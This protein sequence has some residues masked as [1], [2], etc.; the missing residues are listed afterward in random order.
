MEDASGFPAAEVTLPHGASRAHE[1]ILNIEVPI[2]VL[3]VELEVFA[4]S[5]VI[6]SHNAVLLVQRV[7][8]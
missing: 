4:L 1:L 7:I 6:D 3:S 8:L 2:F 5:H